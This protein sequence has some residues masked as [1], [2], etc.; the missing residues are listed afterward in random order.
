MNEWMR[1]Q[2]PPYL[3][4]IESRVPYYSKGIRISPL[5]PPNP[6]YPNELV[7]M[8]AGVRVPIENAAIIENWVDLPSTNDLAEV[9]I[10]GVKSLVSE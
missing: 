2:V 9:S 8:N 7:R 10:V 5:L 6:T 4:L 3:S 1:S